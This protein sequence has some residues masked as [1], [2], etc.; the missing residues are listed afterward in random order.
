M[1]GKLNL[2]RMKNILN[3]GRRVYKKGKELEEVGREVIPVGA[4]GSKRTLYYQEQTRAGAGR[5]KESIELDEDEQAVETGEG[6][7]VGLGGVRQ[8]EGCKWRDVVSGLVRAVLP[9]SQRR[10]RHRTALPSVR[11]QR[12]IQGLS[13]TSD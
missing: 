1:K 3:K 7:V 9:P 12:K 4:E 2:F 6:G 13:G 10:Q 11:R 8:V 5:R